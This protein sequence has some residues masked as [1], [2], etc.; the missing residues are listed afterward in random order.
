M[1]DASPELKEHVALHE[2]GHSFGL[3]DLYD[4]I[5]E[6]Y[7]IMYYASSNI[8]LTDLTEFDILNLEWM[9]KNKE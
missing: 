8:I 6:R 4:A 2:L 5:L 7:S 9:Y 3:D 1:D